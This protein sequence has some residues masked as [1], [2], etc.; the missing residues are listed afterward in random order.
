MG[1]LLK[2][3]QNNPPPF[4]LNVNGHMHEDFY[5]NYNISNYYYKNNDI[6]KYNK[7]ENN[8]NNDTTSNEKEPLDNT[9]RITNPFFQTSNQKNNNKTQENN[10]N[11]KKKK[12]YKESFDFN[13]EIEDEENNK[14]SK[15]KKN[16]YEDEE[17]NMSID[18]DI[19]NK[20]KVNVKIPLYN[21]KVWQKSY[22][23]EE[24]IGNV[25][26]DY[27]KENKLNLSEEYFNEIKYFDKKVTL[28]DKIKTLL[29]KNDEDKNL[30]QNYIYEND[31]N[32]II[33][34][35]Y[36]NE[37]FCDIMAKP[38]FDPFEILC[39]YKSQRKFI[40]LNYNNNIIDKT[41]I[42]QCDL[43]SS[44]CNG[45]NHLYISGGENCINKLWDINLKK[46]IIHDS[47]IIP[48]KKYHS[49]I[50]IPKFIVFVVGGNNL[51]T[52]YYNLKDK[53]LI[54]W[55]KLNI[56]RIEPALQV[57]KN[58]LY[59]VDSAN[60]VSNQT[61]YTI[62]VTELTSN[63]GKWKLLK[64]KLS[65]NAINASFN[66]Q[67]FGVC[68]DKNDNIIFLGGKF[69]SSNNDDNN[70]KDK[71]NN[72]N[73]MYNIINNTIGLS[74]IKYKYFSLKEKG[75]CPFNKSYDYILTDFP[76]ESP[77]IAFLNK[78]RGKIELINFSQDNNS[79]KDEVDKRTNKNIDNKNNQN[80]SPTFS[81]GEKDNN[82][83][84]NNNDIK[85][86]IYVSFRPNE[87]PIE[88]KRT[89]TGLRNPNNKNIN[90]LNVINKNYYTNNLGNTNL[91]VR[92]NTPEF[93]NNNITSKNY[94]INNNYL[95]SNPNTNIVNRNITGVYNKTPDKY[96][97]KYD[98]IY[99]VSNI[100][101]S[102]FNVSQRNYAHSFDS[103]V[104]YY[105]PKIGLNNYV[106]N[107][108]KNIY[109][110]YYNRKYN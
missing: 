36:I 50:F 5:N 97:N 93:V 69:N 100:P 43:T 73:F 64:P 2:Y 88:Q 48:P 56:I 27:I 59:C 51:D 66:Q 84:Q 76:R 103:R 105:Y 81:F 62:E 12:K 4:H 65:Y 83:N 70:D 79:K 19:I 39:F 109:E 58:K 10:Y 54:N 23:T 94:Q 13:N 42:D 61:N 55:G 75:F 98:N 82:Q 24:K 74:Q 49:M 108:N 91:Y 9:S 85:N 77:Q 80:I 86:D 78:R 22:N 30:E 29:P 6:N 68:K 7:N 102:T 38:F 18:I 90:N 89:F 47:V 37:Q 16:R 107:G 53:K 11:K 60:S 67:L 3:D 99:K 34:L 72:F 71:K 46:N 28:Q 31:E 33:D 92:K 8:I 95:Y 21:N 57:V 17:E 14:K 40:I 87:K 101:G 41:K 25:L 32:K 15:N 106:R 96:I 104:R 45:W 44:Y 110:E 35:S 63:K 20:N 26:N 52:F 1:N